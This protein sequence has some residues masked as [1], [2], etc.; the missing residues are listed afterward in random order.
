MQVLRQG[1]FLIGMAIVL[2]LSKGNISSNMLPDQYCDAGRLLS[3]KLGLSLKFAGRSPNS[4]QRRLFNGYRLGAGM[5]SN[6]R[7]SDN[8]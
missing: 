2:G 8:P 7:A 6:G 1:Y 5:T 3:P 4:Y